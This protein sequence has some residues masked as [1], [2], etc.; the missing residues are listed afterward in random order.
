MCRQSHKQSDNRLWRLRNEWPAGGSWAEG[1]IQDTSKGGLVLSTQCHIGNRGVDIASGNWW[2]GDW[3]TLRIIRRNTYRPWNSLDAAEWIS[4][5]ANILIRLGDSSAP[6]SLY[7]TLIC[8]GVPSMRVEIWEFSIE[9]SSNN[10]TS[11]LLYACV[12][13][14]GSGFTWLYARSPST[15]FY[16]SLQLST[17][18]MYSQYSLA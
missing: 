5:K 1:K 7:G 8:L 2:V 3:Q 11:W 9:L 15:S 6:K 12:L 10:L 14:G 18:R 17:P 13:W 4:I 16:S